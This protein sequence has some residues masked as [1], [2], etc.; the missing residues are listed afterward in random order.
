MARFIA[1]LSALFATGIFGV[2][3]ALADHRAAQCNIR[4]PSDYYNCRGIAVQRCFT[5]GKQSKA[6]CNQRKAICERC[7]QGLFTCAK[8]IGHGIVVKRS[9][10]S[11]RAQYS[12]CT[13]NLPK[14]PAD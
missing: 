13:R 11:C 1:A 2:A 9:C 14:Y 3:P 8:K 5:A 7:V 4:A 10:E 6:F 12:Q